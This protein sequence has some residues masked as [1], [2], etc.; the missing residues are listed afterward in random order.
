MPEQHFESSKSWTQN[1]KEPVQL[2]LREQ[3]GSNP[4]KS[5]NSFWSDNCLTVE[6][7]ISFESSV[8]L[9]RRAQGA[10]CI[11]HSILDESAG[12]VRE[13]AGWNWDSSQNTFCLSR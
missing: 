10:L 2:H 7:G 3:A 13:M 11:I 4:N 8:V 6:S 1:C 5:G 9:N 12:Y